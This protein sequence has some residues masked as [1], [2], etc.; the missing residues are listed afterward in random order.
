MRESRSLSKHEVTAP[1]AGVKAWR[2]QLLCA[3][4]AAAV[5]GTAINNHAGIIRERY[6]LGLDPARWAM[7]AWAR[8]LGYEIKGP[9]A[10]HENGMPPLSMDGSVVTVLRDLVDRDGF[11]LLADKHRFWAL[12]KDH[13]SGSQREIAVLT[14]ALRAQLPQRLLASPAAAMTAAALND[15]TATLV[16]E[17]ALDATA[18]RWA[19]E[20][21]AEAVRAS[22]TSQTRA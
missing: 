11:E 6:G 20:T 10:V 7:A 21:W 4:P 17:E 16:R 18:A 22:R 5:T 3:Q 2:V 13:C 9:I 15:H 14:V 12:L 1:I 8:A 19:V